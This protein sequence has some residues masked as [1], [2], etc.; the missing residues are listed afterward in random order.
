MLIDH[1]HPFTVFTYHGL[2][3]SFF[4]QFA[5]FYFHYRK[6]KGMF[7]C[8]HSFLEVYLYYLIIFLYGAWVE[9]ESGIFFYRWSIDLMTEL[10]SHLIHFLNHW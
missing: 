4:G 2:D 6:M 5:L 3:T 8:S 9:I 10:F 1:A 7:S